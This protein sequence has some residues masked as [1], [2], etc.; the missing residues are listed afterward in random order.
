MKTNQ[1][2]EATEAQPP[3]NAFLMTLAEAGNGLLAAEAAEGLQA[4]IKALNENP[5][6]GKLSVTLNFASTGSGQVAFDYDVSHKVPKRK[7]A[8][9]IRYATEEGALVK[10]DPAQ[11]ELPFAVHSAVEVM[12]PKIHAAG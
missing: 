7:S 10:Q 3:S 8:L 1:T 9:T 2:T 12:K 11:R 6:K 5:G 4:V